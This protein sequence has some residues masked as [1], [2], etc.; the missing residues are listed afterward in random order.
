MILG[1]AGC[2]PV[3]GAAGRRRGGRD[4]ERGA[5][6]LTPAQI[7]PRGCEGPPFWQRECSRVTSY[8]QSSQGCWRS[9]GT[10]SA[11]EPNV[12]AHRP[13]W[14]WVWDGCACYVCPCMSSAARD[15]GSASGPQLAQGHL[16]VS[17]CSRPAGSATTPAR[18]TERLVLHWH[19]TA[20]M[21]YPNKCPPS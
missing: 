18:L 20:V 3:A 14:G 16:P 19:R 15:G 12:A 7:P 5:L 13:L 21:A 2:E 17:Q 4:G 1:S 11:T 9:R 8:A 6:G 10:P